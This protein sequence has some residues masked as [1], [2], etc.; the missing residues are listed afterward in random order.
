MINCTY[1][2]NLQK[3]KTCTDYA[4][5]YAQR[6]DGLIK[7]P[8]VMFEKLD[9]LSEY[10]D[11]DMIELN[12]FFGDKVKI[13]FVSYSGWM[14]TAKLKI[15]QLN[16]LGLNERDLVI[17]VHYDEKEGW[18]VFSYSQDTNYYS[19]SLHNAL[20]SMFQETF[21]KMLKVQA[22]R[23]SLVEDFISKKFVEDVKTTSIQNYE[24]I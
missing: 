7:I 9:E 1:E 16:Y 20:Y 24:V 21:V 14:I 6:S 15:K 10:I 2:V 11:N 19:D 12:Q 18:A 3:H 5:E 17:P 13:T 8:D 22:E 4:L 23:V